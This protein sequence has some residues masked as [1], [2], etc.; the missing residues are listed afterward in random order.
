M[1]NEISITPVS[2]MV[3]GKT[4]ALRQMSVIKDASSDALSAALTMKGK[5]GNAIRFSAAE[6][7][8]AKVAIAASNANYR[9][10]A[11]LLALRLGEP[12]FISNRAS[13]EALPDT[14]R[15]KIAMAQ[16]GTNEGQRYVAKTDEW[17]DGAKLQLARELL[18]LCERVIDYT[19]RVYAERTT[20]I[21]AE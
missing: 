14:F 19:Q 13:F 15:A 7:G 12:V 8:L 3:E 5:V 6:T 18:T 11:E 9:P 10:L 2:I 21:A 17:V 20:K 16:L 1:S 4:K